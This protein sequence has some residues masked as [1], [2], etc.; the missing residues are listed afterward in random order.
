LWLADPHAPVD[1]QAETVGRR[2]QLRKHLAVSE[3][4]VV[5]N[6]KARYPPCERLGH[7][8]LRSIRAYRTAV[9][10]RHI[11]SCHPGTFPFGE[12]QDAARP[13]FLT[14]P[15]IEPDIAYVRASPTVND[16][17]IQEP[18]GNAV[19][20]ARR[21]Q[22]AVGGYPAELSVQRGSKQQA[23]VGHEPHAG[24]STGDLCLE[25]HCATE[26][27]RLERVVVDVGEPQSL[28]VPAGRLRK[29]DFLRKRPHVAHK[30]SPR[31][32]PAAACVDVDNDSPRIALYIS[33]ITHCLALPRSPTRRLT[34]SLTL[35]QAVLS[36][37][38]P[39]IRLGNRDAARAL[40]RRVNED[41][42]AAVAAHPG[43]FGLFASL[44][45]P[46]IDASLEEIAYASDVLDADGFVLMT[47]Y[48]GVYPADDTLK[49]VIAELDRRE[50]V[51]A[52][53]PTSP[54]GWEAVAR[55]R[56]RPMLEF[57]FDTTR[58]V[59]DLILSRRLEHHPRIRLIVPH[60]GSALSVL[61][62][63]VHAFRWPLPRRE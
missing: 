57:P 17:V 21:G 30:D 54:P 43:G 60:V 12:Q 58:A 44:P 46:D 11:L 51:V 14:G 19:E 55:G 52:L 18:G 20:V 9:G 45:L 53:R 36:I 39:G 28:V 25:H 8:V 16:H 29:D 48:D 33:C 35:E 32:S 26:I 22:R 41:G 4:P 6:A 31:L 7:E 5:R 24:W 1:I 34:Y 37:S 56:P 62:D 63:R 2:I 50:A 49:D 42:A 27:R 23:P 38:S 10:E 47:N 13:G 3:H 61:A 40:A 59:F 15:E